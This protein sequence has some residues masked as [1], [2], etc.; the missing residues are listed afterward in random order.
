MVI[1]MNKIKL[2]H[3]S[4]VD[5]KGCIKP[6]FFGANSYTQHS[7]RESL[8]LRSFFY[9]GKGKE[10]F[11]NG[12]KYLYTAELEPDK[13]YDLNIDPKELKDKYTFSEI[14][15]RVKSFGYYGIKGNNGF[16]VVCLFKAIKYID[17]QT[18]TR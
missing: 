10:W 1:K 9:I 17:K 11:L 7:R 5:F 13:I 12:A 18:L 14:L 16:D 3:Y 8:L 2:Y 4:N 15:R 6:S